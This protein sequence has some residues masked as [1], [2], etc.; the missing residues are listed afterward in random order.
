VAQSVY[1]P[2]AGPHGNPAH[3]ADSVQI[4]VNKKLFM[5]TRTFRRTPGFAKLK[6]DIDA[7]LRAV[8]VDTRQRVGH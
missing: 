1:R 7:L 5:D 2:P 4:E 8:A 6:A 3:G